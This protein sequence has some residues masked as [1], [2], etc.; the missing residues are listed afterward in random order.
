MKMIEVI[1]GIN[2]LALLVFCVFYSYFNP[3][4][5]IVAGVLVFAGA[6]LL[7][8]LPYTITHPSIP[9]EKRRNE[10]KYSIIAGWS[11]VLFFLGMLTRSSSMEIMG[12]VL[13]GT[14][15][16]HFIHDVIKWKKEHPE[17]EMKGDGKDNPS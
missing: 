7:S 15:A 9:E 16:I 12:L 4:L 1:Q 3:Y 14:Y 17:K 8:Y 11:F 13:L 5:D 6:F 2:A 10:K